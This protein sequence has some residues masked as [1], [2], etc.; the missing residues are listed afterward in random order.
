MAS[1]PPPYTHAHIHTVGRWVFWCCVFVWMD[2][3]Y[4]YFW[5]SFPYLLVGLRWNFP[6]MMRRRSQ[7]SATRV[8]SLYF[9]RKKKVHR[10]DMCFLKATSSLTLYDLFCVLP[11]LLYAWH[12]VPIFSFQKKI[13]I[14]FI[15]SVS[16]N[17]MKQTILQYGQFDCVNL[18]MPMTHVLWS[19]R[20]WYKFNIIDNFYHTCVLCNVIVIHNTPLFLL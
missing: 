6:K 16:K 18:F 1:P 19:T 14:K 2:E 8:T 15:W 10:G 5:A 13:N 7:L 9:G 12:W 4:K 17:L 20:L 11:F 3:H